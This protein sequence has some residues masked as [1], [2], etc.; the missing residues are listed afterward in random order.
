MHWITHLFDKSAPVQH[1]LEGSVCNFILYDI[2]QSF[3]SQRNILLMFLTT[4]QRPSVPRSSWRSCGPAR[5]WRRAGSWCVST[6]R[7]ATGWFPWS[8][9]RQ[10][11]GSSSSSATTTN[12]ATGGSRWWT[13]RTRSISAPNPKSRS[14]TRWQS[15]SWGEHGRVK[16]LLTVNG[17]VSL[18]ATCTLQARPSHLDVRMRRGSGALLLRPH[19]KGGRES[20]Q[21]EAVRHRHRSVFKLG[22][23]HADV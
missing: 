3:D 18:N 10:S 16:W 12:P 17:V 7:E 14:A 20:G 2:S 9:Q 5:T 8:R 4:Q 22:E 15:R 13:W 1:I 23:R 11:V 19:R 6:R 21:R